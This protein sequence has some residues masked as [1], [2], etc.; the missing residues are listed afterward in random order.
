MGRTSRLLD[1]RRL[2]PDAPGVA[3]RRRRARTEVRAAALKA[4]VGEA[5]DWREFIVN[6]AREAHK[7]DVARELELELE[8]QNR[9]EAERRKELA[10]RPLSRP[11]RPALPRAGRGGARKAGGRGGEHY[12]SAAPVPPPR[13][14]W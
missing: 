14:S 9:K 12:F 1:A 6:G 3:Q 2:P 5:A 4:L 13:D 7:R 10:A 8:E 11:G